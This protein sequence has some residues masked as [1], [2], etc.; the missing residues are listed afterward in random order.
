MSTDLVNIFFYL[1]KLTILLETLHSQLLQSIK[2]RR[3]TCMSSNLYVYFINVP[4]LLGVC[5]VPSVV[6]LL[7]SL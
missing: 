2:A 1:K 7:I 3:N 6:L 5:I 4:L